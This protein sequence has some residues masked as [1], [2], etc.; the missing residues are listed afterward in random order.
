MRRCDAVSYAT[1]GLSTA[2][3][4]QVPSL[5]LW[6]HKTGPCAIDVSLVSDRSG[7]REAVR[8]GGVTLGSLS[9]STRVAARV[10]SIGTEGGRRKGG[11]GIERNRAES[12]DKLFRSSRAGHSVG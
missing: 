1:W 4:W 11:S 6:C 9:G 5:W 3:R 7:R 12:I 10:A 8:C 2:N